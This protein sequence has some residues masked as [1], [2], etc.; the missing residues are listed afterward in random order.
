M[1][2]PQTMRTMP[3]HAMFRGRTISGH[4]PEQYI[5]PP[6]KARNTGSHDARRLIIRGYRLTDAVRNLTPAWSVGFLRSLRR[7]QHC[8]NCSDQ[9]PDTWQN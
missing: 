7:C 1:R 9:G 4:H 6:V 3:S 8:S 5:V 2:H